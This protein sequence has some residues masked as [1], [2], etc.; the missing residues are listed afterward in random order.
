MKIEQVKMQPEQARALLLATEGHEQRPISPALVDRLT[1]AIE[2]GR[3][4]MTHQAIAISKHGVIID[5]RHRLSAIAR[6]NAA[7]EVMVAYD[8]D[9]ATFRS[10]DVG[11]SRT[12]GDLLHIAGHQNTNQLAAVCRFLMAYEQVAGTTLPWS[13]AVNHVRADQII[14]FADAHRSELHNSMATGGRIAR[15]FGRY[16]TRTW[17]STAV[18]IIRR[19]DTSPEIQNEYLERLSDGTNLGPGSP[20]LALRRYITQSFITNATAIKA[21]V[22]IAVTIK[23]YNAWLAGASVQLAQFRLGIEK[24]PQVGEAPVSRRTS[25]RRAAVTEEEPAKEAVGV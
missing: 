11:R 18:F 17:V 5:G 3:W 14:A 7:V 22:G 21:P 19:S 10:I 9:P 24:M 25:Q 23:A 1:A 6:A 15:S 12:P 2:Q 16:G 20:I 8:A 4:Q 13:S